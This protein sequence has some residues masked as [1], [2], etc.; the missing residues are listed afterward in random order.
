[1]WKGDTGTDGG[2]ESDDTEKDAENEGEEEEGPTHDA[3][4]LWKAERENENNDRVTSAFN[5]Q[6]DKP[7]KN[8]YSILWADKG[9]D[10]CYQG[11]IL[12]I[13]KYITFLTSTK[14]SNPAK[15]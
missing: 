8:V 3:G 10:I 11:K 7:A 14:F 1:M 5:L 4:E 12:Y 13:I 15:K 9:I 6:S 2:A